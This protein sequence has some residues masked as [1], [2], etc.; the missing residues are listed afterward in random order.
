MGECQ[1]YEQTRTA[2]ALGG[3]YTALA[4]ERVLPIL[5][6]GPGCLSACGGFLSVANG[7]SI[8]VTYPDSAVP[9]TNF[10]EEDVIFGGGERL[11]KLTEEALKYYKADLA[12]IA[13]GC[14]SAIVGDDIEEVAG[15]F[16]GSEIPVFHVSLPGFKGNNVWGHSQ[17]LN[18]IID[19]YLKPREVHVNKGQVNVFGIIPYFDPYWYGT[20]EQLKQLLLDLGLKP[21]IIYGP[22][23][24]VAAL[25]RVP[26]AEFNLVLAPWSDLD[27]AEKLEEKFGTPYFHYPC[28]PVGIS[29]TTDFIRAITEYA[30]LN[31]LN[32]ETIVKNSEKRIYYFLQQQAKI[33]YGGSMMPKRLFVN[34]SS[35][36]A[37]SFVRFAIRDMSFIPYKVFIT[38]DV[39]AEHQAYIIEKLKEH[40]YDGWHD[41]DVIFTTDG[42]ACDVE[43]KKKTDWSLSRATLLGTTWD[44][45]TAKNKAFP[46]IAV[47]A[48]SGND[49]IIDKSYFGY[50]GELTFIRDLLNDSIRKFLGSG[51]VAKLDI[52][53]NPAP[54]QDIQVSHVC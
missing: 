20:L 38:E 48:P 46:F 23:N 40:K 36:A 10:C 17:V 1:L 47:S 53:K 43:I 12:I 52:A 4:I 21:N 8:P 42:G 31:A 25:N 9:C 44:E 33:W 50:N 41:F 32:A 22:G 39:P 27:I 26:D 16:E 28:V 34:A 29:E 45:L 13:D 5:H 6:A 30:D 18:A 15:S 51:A 24:G 49:V 35:A 14:T 2:C 37:V 11:R 54:E 3:I 7:L 19:Q